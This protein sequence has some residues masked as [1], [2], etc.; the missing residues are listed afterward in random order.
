MI[1]KIVNSL[2]YR[3]AR[4]GIYD[5]R[6]FKTVPVDA[7]AVSPRQSIYD[8]AAFGTYD[9]AAQRVV[10]KADPAA[11]PFS[12]DTIRPSAQQQRQKG[13]ALDI[14]RYA[15]VLSMLEPGAGICLDACTRTPRDD[16]RQGVERE[17]YDYRPID[18]D[19]PRNSG[20][21][22]EDLMKLS[23]A[24]GSIARI[25][26]CDTIE[27][28][29]DYR[30]AA[31]EMLRVLQPG[32]LLIIHFPV[33]FFD[34]AEGEPIRPGVDP[35]DHVRYFSAREMLALF[36]EIGFV[37]MRAHFNFDYGALLSVLCRPL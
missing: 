3:T 20:V 26:S 37:V 22:R 5:A 6:R 9:L 24:D 36:G 21:A 30:A 4:L 25:I 8:P 34:R 29:P 7:L 31:A 27:H 12:L 32:G 19:P 1:S 28:I 10:A 14:D 33:Y 13:V 11:G 15:L 23:F 35:W 16:V 17:G 2:L 18:I